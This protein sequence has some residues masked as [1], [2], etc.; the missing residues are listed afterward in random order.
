MSTFLDRARERERQRLGY[1]DPTDDVE[2]DDEPTAAAKT[3]TIGDQQVDLADAETTIVFEDTHNALSGDYGIPRPADFWH[4]KRVGQTPPMQ[5]IKAIVTRQLRGGTVTP[6]VAEGEELDD[7]AEGLAGLVVDIYDGP[8]HHLKMWDDLLNETVH[9]MLDSAWAYWELVPSEDGEFP[10]A[11]FKT[12]PPLQIQHNV[13]EGGDL[14]RDSDEPAVW[15]VPHT[16][17]TGAITMGDPTPLS[18]DQVVVMRAPDSAESDR[19]Y[20]ES[21]ATKV[22]EYL[23]LIVDVDVH[24]KR[25]YADSHLPAGFMHFIG[26]NDKDL[27]GIERDIAEVAGDPQELVAVSTNDSASWIPVGGEVADLEALSQQQWYWQLVLA[28]IGLNQSEIN[29]VESSGFAKENPTLQKMVYKNVTKPYLRAIMDPQN[30]HVLPRMATGFGVESLPFDV[31]LERFDP[32]HEQIER[33]QQLEEWS[34]GELSLA[35]LRGADG[36]DTEEYPIEIA[37][38]EL[39]IARTPRYVV[40]QLVSLES[41][42]PLGTGN[43]NGDGTGNN[44]SNAVDAL[45]DST[46]SNAPLGA[47]DPVPLETVGEAFGVDAHA[48]QRR[49]DRNAKQIEGSIAVDSSF[50]VSAAYDERVDPPF[51]QLEFERDDEPNW[52]YWYADVE[53]FRFFNFLRADSKGRYFNAHIRDE[54]QYARVS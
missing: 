18:F 30:R 27:E 10:V 39:D 54:Y 3:T 53:R 16:Q 13:T 40:E 1:V 48:L 43:G 49:L 36:K 44:N 19:L 12:L 7:A 26:V 37:G 23:D 8:H 15:H 21:V 11:A 4:A 47:D 41:P 25:H 6:A 42:D 5:I 31:E 50:L 52:T 32:V 24:Q 38:T 35:E 2:T 46:T 22:R 34:A 17:R 14:V 45:G 51:M 9:D 20:G 29:M 33:D 28:A